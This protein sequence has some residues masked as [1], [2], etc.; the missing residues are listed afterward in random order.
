[1]YVHTCMH[2]NVFMC[3]CFC[4]C[5][6][7]HLYACLCEGRKENGKRRDKREQTREVRGEQGNAKRK[8]KTEK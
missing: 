5:P 3:L 4:L 8:E 7:L 6:C 1:M 2:S